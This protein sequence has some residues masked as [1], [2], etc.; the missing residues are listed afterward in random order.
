MVTHHKVNQNQK[1]T[2]NLTSRMRRR[3]FLGKLT[4]DTYTASIVIVIDIS[5][6]IA[7]IAK[8]VSYMFLVL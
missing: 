1:I 5:R 3:K 2:V 7:F 8:H 6:R 4:P